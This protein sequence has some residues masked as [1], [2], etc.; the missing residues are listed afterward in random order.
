M[1]FFFLLIASAALV[2]RGN[3]VSS[4]MPQTLAERPEL[5]DMPAAYAMVHYNFYA[6]DVSAM[7]VS[8]FTPSASVTWVD[9][10]TA[11]NALGTRVMGSSAS[12]TR[13][14]ASRTRRC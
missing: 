10:G 12:G 9:F 4:A 14:T 8:Y 13:A 3:E 2:A 6:A 5:G 7:L 11:P 1:S